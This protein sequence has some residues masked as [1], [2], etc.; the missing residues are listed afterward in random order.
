[1]IEPPGAIGSID[2][3]AL[4]RTVDGGRTLFEHN[5]AL[6]GTIDVLRPQYGLPAC[7]Y[8]TFGDDEVVIAIALHELCALGDRTLIDS[9][10][11]VEQ[12]L[13]ISRHPMHD[14]RTC[15]VFATP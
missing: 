5:F 3:G 8:T 2:Q 4:M 10:A 12:L 7:A 11:L 9:G 15:A 6:V 14:D 13:A 1:M